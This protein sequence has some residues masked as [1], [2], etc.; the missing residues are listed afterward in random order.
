MERILEAVVL[1]TWLVLWGTGGWLLA[2]GVFDLRRHEN[3]VV[4]FALGLV[5]EIWITNLISHL[6]PIPLSFWLSGLLV[7]LGGIA[8][9][10]GRRGRR[11]LKFVP[12]QWLA[13]GLLT[14]LFTAI[15]RGLGIFDDYQNLPTVSLM[16]A[17]DVPPHFALDPSLRF[18]YH[19]LLLLFAAQLMRL[20]SLL[21]WSALD[22]ARGVMLALPLILGGLWIHRLTHRTLAAVLGASLLAFAGGARWLLLLLPPEWLQRVSAQVTLI[23]SAATSAPNLAEAMIS[24][25]KIDGAGPIPFPFA[26][27]SGMNQAYVMG[28]TGIAGSATLILL[29]LLLTA[30][31]WRRGTAAAAITVALLAALAIAN[32]IAFLLVG[33][34]I[35]ITGLARLRMIPRLGGFR[36]HWIWIGLMVVA[37]VIAILQGGMLTEIVL[38]WLSR[39][40]V[41]TSYFDTTPAISWPPSL[42]SAHLG[43]L[44]LANPVHVLLV[45]LEIGPA[46]AVTPLVLAR[47]WRSLNRGRWL[48]ASLIASSLGVLI[49]AFVSFKGPL[50][51]AAPRLLSSWFLVSSLYFVPLL[52]FWAARRRDVVRVAAGATGVVSGIG[53]LVLLSVQLAAIQRPVFATFITQIDAKVAA[54]HWNDLR[55][56]ALVF[57]PLVFRAPTVFGRPTRS[58]PTW[59]TRSED[60]E[61][62]RDGA[63]PGAIGAA[64]FDYMYFDREYWDQLTSGQ[65]DALQ[66]G[67]VTQLWQVDGIRDESDYRM[68]F[69]RL[70]DI[71]E[72][73]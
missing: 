9:G 17:G 29:L 65:R 67:C 44:S 68:D 38:A 46:I 3:A 56:G 13:L 24:N 53:G 71:R 6:M 16:A 15:G 1:V 51:T 62:L 10:I 52:W 72:C 2:A 32:E 61:V 5:L 7:L 20:G 25:W 22:L 41:A 28:H 43:S 73:R 49:A 59:Y 36:E 12:G 21:P 60:W 4:G 39:D 18:G 47:G 70:L 64:G 42:V 69:R 34:G 57:D 14:L 30:Q 40:A 19:Y 66:G 37:V 50:F 63:D 27:H 23:G 45:L 26:Y 54:D 48:E 33:F 55:P 31:R 58:S 8:A 11:H 35:L